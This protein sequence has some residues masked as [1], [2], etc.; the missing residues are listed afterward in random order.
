MP[1]APEAAT[2][3]TAATGTGY[4]RDFAY[5]HQTGHSD[6]VH[7]ATP[8]VLAEL[9]AAGVAGGLVVDL[10]CGTGVLA[11]ALGHAGY[12]VLGVDLSADMLDLARETA[13]GATFVHGSFLDVALPPCDAVVSV[14]QCLAYAID[15]RNDAA[16]LSG[17]FRRIAAAL[18]PGGMLLFDLNAPVE[19]GESCP[20]PHP[21]VRVTPEWTL[22]ADSTVDDGVLTRE[23]VLFR[24]VDEHYRRTDERHVVRLYEPADVLAALREAG[25]HASTFHG[26]GG[27]E[28]PP[29]LVGYRARR[30]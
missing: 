7:L 15:P 28:F 10:G 16:A 4:G 26:Y 23:F 30:P 1:P 11:A 18:R 22:L 6:F 13:P 14:G 3:A 9:R 2:A 19:A 20:R 12:D 29:D 25:L 5:A 21:Q 8:T 17:L 24:K 27:S